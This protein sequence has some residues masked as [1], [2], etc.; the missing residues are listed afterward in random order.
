MN[1]TFPQV[2]PLRII[3]MLGTLASAA[4]F[5]AF[6]QQLKEY[7]TGLL[8]QVS[9]IVGMLLPI[10]FALI[11]LAFFWGLVKFVFGGTKDNTDQGKSLMIWSVIAL[12]VAASVWGIV[13]LMQNLFGTTDQSVGVPK[14]EL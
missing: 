10:V 7:G 9:Q 8:G 11:V 14:V 13:N 2:S 6:A 5:M 1:R 12:F 3:L 4:P